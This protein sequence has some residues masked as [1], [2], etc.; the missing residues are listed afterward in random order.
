MLQV[1]LLQQRPLHHILP[2]LLPRRTMVE[3]WLQCAMSTTANHGE[4][5]P[6]GR[7]SARGLFPR[8]A[9]RVAIYAA[10]TIPRDATRSH[11][12]CGFGTPDILLDPGSGS[13]GLTLTEWVERLSSITQRSI[14]QD[15][16]LPSLRILNTVGVVEEV[17]NNRQQQTFQLVTMRSLLS[18]SNTT[19]LDPMVRYLVDE[20]LWRAWELF[21]PTFNNGTL[22]CRF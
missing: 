2:I 3:P 5:K 18:T 13:E 17:E 20:P 9:P 16:L 15:G 19:S 10:S 6:N 12:L 7:R 4:A 21:H 22:L 1:W 14:R 8:K 11:G